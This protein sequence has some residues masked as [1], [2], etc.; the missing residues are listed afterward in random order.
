[1][2]DSLDFAGQVLILTGSPGSGKTTTAA[3]LT[4]LPGSPKVH[5]HSDDFWHFI[6]NGCIPPY[7]PESHEQN[8][9]VMTALAKVVESFAE[10]KFFVVLDGIIGP[11]FLDYFKHFNVPTHYV[12]LQPPLELAIQRC[13]QRNPDTL[14]D[15]GPITGLHEQ[16]STLGDLQNHSLAVSVG[17]PEDMVPRV[18]DALQSGAF[19][20]KTV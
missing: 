11:W 17:A 4:A 18:I 1:M 3:L 13:K 12:V 16:F 15:S 5:L 6:K 20:L 14:T 10:G 19:L 2:V 8:K 9:V 7:L